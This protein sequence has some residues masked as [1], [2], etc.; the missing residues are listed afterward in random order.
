M[1]DVEKEKAYRN[2][3]ANHEDF[4]LNDILKRD[5]VAV[6]AALDEEIMRTNDELSQ[7]VYFLRADLESLQKTLE[8][9]QAVLEERKHIQST[10]LKKLEEQQAKT[11]SVALEKL[12]RT[13]EKQLASENHSLMRQLSAFLDEYY[14]DYE[15]TAEEEEEMDKEEL[16][17][18]NKKRKE[19]GTCVGLKRFL[20][21]LMN[22]IVTEPQFPYVKLD[23]ATH[24]EPYVEL[25]IR[26]GVAEKHP[27][28]SRLL[29][30]I[31]Y[32]EFF[33]VIQLL[34]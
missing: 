14:D 32:H 9:E 33:L 19:R 16:E 27:S 25:L 22:K 26:G 20:L 17:R 12:L 21:D 23:P 31:S 5:P 18:I 24:W 11:N 4:S 29:K 30:L 2:E 7:T 34:I 13:K 10:L 3:I 6:Q 8:E 15:Y 28:D 1:I